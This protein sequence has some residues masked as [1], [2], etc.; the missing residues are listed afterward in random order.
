MISLV[1]F[2]Y[3]PKTKDKCCCC[4]NK[5]PGAEI[6]IETYILSVVLMIVVAIFVYRYLRREGGLDKEDLGGFCIVSSIFIL[7]PGLNSFALMIVAIIATAWII[8]TLIMWII[9]KIKR[10][11]RNL[12]RG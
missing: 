4:E 6:P 2:P 3:V 12:K 8:F 7:I 5:E 11:I 9:K 10:W 1:V